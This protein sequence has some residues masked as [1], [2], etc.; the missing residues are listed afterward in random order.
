MTYHPPTAEGAPR[1]GGQG[2]FNVKLDNISNKVFICFCR[3][4]GVAE[5]DKNLIQAPRALSLC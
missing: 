4:F 5:T 2:N 1:A 3:T